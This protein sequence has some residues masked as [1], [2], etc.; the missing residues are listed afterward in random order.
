MPHN[1]PGITRRQEAG[2]IVDINTRLENY[3]TYS[4]LLK[5]ALQI[6]A[7]KNE[8]KQG[9]FYATKNLTRARA[10]VRTLKER[11]DENYDSGLL[12]QIADDLKY[13]EE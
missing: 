13:A 6:N 8:Y 3:P 4:T 2:G 11:L 10:R 5:R 7:E 1:Y 12:I 9:M